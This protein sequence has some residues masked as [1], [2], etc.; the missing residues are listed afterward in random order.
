VANRR[1]CAVQQNPYRVLVCADCFY[2]FRQFFSE[3]RAGLHKSQVLDGLSA[4]PAR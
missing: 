3:P 4:P 1:N 2:Q